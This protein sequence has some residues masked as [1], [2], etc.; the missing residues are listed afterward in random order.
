MKRFLIVV[1]GSIVMMQCSYAGGIGKFFESLA[2]SAKN[3]SESTAR[4]LKKL[5]NNDPSALVKRLDDIPSIPKT[6]KGNEAK[7]LI[8]T[9]ADDIIKKGDYE[10]RFFEN[11]NFDNQMVM[12]V[13]SSKYGDDYFQIAK[14]LSPDDL[15]LLSINP[16]L[17]KYMTTGMTTQALQSKFIETLQHTGERGWEVLKEIGTFA[18]NNPKITTISTAYLWYTLDPISFEEK[19]KEFGGSIPDFL[20]SVVGSVGGG[21]AEV[22]EQKIDYSIDT[23]ISETKNGS[24]EFL[25]KNI[26]MLILFISVFFAWRKRRIIYYHLVKAD[27]LPQEKKQKNSL[28]KHIQKDD[29][30]Y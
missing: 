16:K 10:K 5:T 6:I 13:Q 15:K 22:V 25:K 20:T 7:T 17:S 9:K 12:I 30:E 29:N 23:V 26:L 14:K 8:A 3:T 1:M 24:I 4:Q 27:D 21:A 18:I 28:S 2:K 11:Q 19:L